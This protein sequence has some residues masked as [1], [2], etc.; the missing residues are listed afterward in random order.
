M[1]RRRLKAKRR[2]LLCSKEDGGLRE[3]AGDGSLSG[4]CGGKGVGSLANSEAEDRED[5]PW[6]AW[7]GFQITCDCW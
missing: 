5:Q 1:E 4:S 3:D 2:L 7:S 6:R